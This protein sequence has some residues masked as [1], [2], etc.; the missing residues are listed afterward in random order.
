MVRASV[1]IPAREAEA[2]IGRT[3]ACLA[4][5]RTGVS[6]E[7]IVVDDGSQDA[8]AAIAE[9]APG[10][11]RVLRQEAEGAAAA[12]N[13]GVAE[14]RGE[15]L[16]F[17]DADCYPTAGW[18]EAGMQALG[19]CDLVQG[20][21]GPEPDVSIGPYDRSLWIESEV[22]LWETANLFVSRE[23]FDGAGGF[24]DWLRLA[25]GRPMAE[26]VWF[27]WRVKRLG[28]RS[29]FCA[30]ALV[31]HAVFQRTPKEYVLERRRLRHFPPMVGKM[32]E[33]RRAFLHRRLFLNERT[34]ALDAALAGL[35]AAALARRPWPLIAAVPYA[36]VVRQGARGQSRPAAEVA[37][38]H[39]LADLIGAAALARGGVASRTPV[40]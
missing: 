38:V 14:S 16:A 21:V 8:T 33:L 13:R 34:A 6:F 17:C 22:G 27:G 37:A 18:L 1:I 25:G 12:R 26:D 31:H 24:E 20:K 28:A 35:A 23:F 15:A 7:T 10:E 40:L 32:P 30:E 11:V 5:Q 9:A 2:T 4:G 39:V 19:S 3:L 29:A 36:G